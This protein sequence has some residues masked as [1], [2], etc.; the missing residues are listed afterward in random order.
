MSNN[1]FTFQDNSNNSKSKPPYKKVSGTP[2][3]GTITKT[4]GTGDNAKNSLVWITI[5]WSFIIGSFITLGIYLYAIYFQ[6]EARNNLLEDIKS[7][8]SIF[9][10]LI[11]LAL[12]YTF[13]KGK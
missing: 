6:S 12:G 3:E 7:I 10:P 8:W 11:T 5:Q 13:G 1:Q 4:I 9:I 2:S